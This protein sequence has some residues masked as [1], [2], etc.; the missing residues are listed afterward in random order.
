[1]IGTTAKSG[2][3]LYYECNTHYKK[4]KHGCHGIRVA[5]DKLEGF[6]LSRIKENILTEENLTELVYLVNEE[7]LETT[8]RNEKEL[9]QVEKQLKQVSKRLSKLYAALEGGKLDLDDLAPRIKELRM[10]QHELQECRNQLLSNIESKNPEALDAKIVMSYVKEL[11]QL[12]VQASFLQQKSFLRSFVKRVEVKPETIILDYTI[13]L[14]IKKN[15]TSSREVLD[16][17]RFG[18]GGWIRTNDLRV[19]GPISYHYESRRHIDVFYLRGFPHEGQF[20]DLAPTTLIIPNILPQFLHLTLV[21][22]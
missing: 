6:V 7:L 21:S 17:N 16:I 14:P 19:M 1:M 20:I 11:E 4:G 2:K 5:R 12:L 9:H 3:Y 8:S 18:S 22:T 13:P 10:D 15:R